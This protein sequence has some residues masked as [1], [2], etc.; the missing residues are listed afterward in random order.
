MLPAT[1]EGKIILISIQL[2][3]G[4][5]NI[6]RKHHI[7]LSPLKKQSEKT[8]TEEHAKDTSPLI[9]GTIV[10]IN[11][12]GK[13]TREGNYYDGKVKRSA[14]QFAGVKHGIFHRIRLPSPPPQPKQN[15]G[16]AF[17][18]GCLRFVCFQT[19]LTIDGIAYRGPATHF[20]TSVNRLR[21]EPSQSAEQDTTPPVTCLA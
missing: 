10:S 4:Y 18:T 17:R 11:A 12:Q 7:V 6:R 14:S 2:S 9:W 5:K 16:L 21:T 19:T 1:Q 15:L 3:R 8:H 20:T 13:T